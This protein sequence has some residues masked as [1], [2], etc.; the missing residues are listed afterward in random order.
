MIQMSLKDRPVQCSGRVPVESLETQPLS[1]APSY[2]DSGVKEAESIAFTYTQC[3]PSSI[4]EMKSQEKIEG[5]E[6]E[7]KPNH[8]NI[9]VICHRDKSLDEGS[10][11]IGLN[12][13]QD[14]T[15]NSFPNTMLTMVSD[16]SH[17]SAT[18]SFLSTDD[19]S[20]SNLSIPH[21][22]S[23]C[24]ST[25]VRSLVSRAKVPSSEER[26]E[27]LV[28]ITI[29]D[30]GGQEVFYTTHQTFLS[31]SCIYMMAFNLFEFWQESKSIKTSNK[32]LGKGLYKYWYS[33]GVRMLN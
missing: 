4:D 27:R 16:D 6:T 33:E 17:N 20:R 30:F 14:N 22:V 3:P 29:W 26:L 18:A 21:S 32:T 11:M 28:P 13:N 1:P 7:N 8:E 19:N 25:N 31:S 15:L 10:E 5:N 2:Q 23:P 24:S 9:T 12:L